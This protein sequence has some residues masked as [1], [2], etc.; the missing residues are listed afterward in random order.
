MSKNVGLSARK[1]QYTG[2]IAWRPTITT[3]SETIDS[4]E[5]NI[6]DAMYVGCGFTC[7]ATGQLFAAATTALHLPSYADLPSSDP[8]AT[9]P[10]TTRHRVSPSVSRDH[11]TN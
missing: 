4:L 5:L 6:L 1:T 2:L 8:A 11:L 3:R 9:Q 10:G 7:Y